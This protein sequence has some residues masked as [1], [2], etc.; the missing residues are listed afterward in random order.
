MTDVPVVICGAGPVGL[1]AS[2]ILSRFGIANMLIERRASPN[3]LPRARS[4]NCRTSE[5]WR[6]FGLEEDMKSISLPPEW[7]QYMVYQT[8]LAGEIVGK[9][10]GESMVQGA[11]SDITP[12]LFLLSSQDR[13]E[14]MLRETAASYATASVRYS[15]ELSTF[16]ADDE[17]VTIEVTNIATGVTETVR[18]QWLIAADGANSKIR[19][20]LGVPMEGEE[21]L[22]WYVNNHFHADLS[23]WTPGREGALLWI[24]GKGLE[25]VFQPLDGK[26][27]WMCQVNFDPAV[28]PASTFTREWVLNRIHAMIGDPAAANIEIELISSI[29]WSVAKMVATRLRVGRVLLAGDAAHRVPPFGGFGMNTGIQ[30]AHNLGWKLAY[31]LQKIAP[32][33]LLDSY[34]EERREVAQ[35]NCEF[36]WKNG[37]HVIAIG[38]AGSVQGGTAAVASAR[39]YGNWA[40]LDLGVY[41]ERGALVPDGTALPIVEDPIIDYVPCARPGSR[42]P[43]LWLR[44]N[45]EIISSLDLSEKDFVILAGP[46]GQAWVDAIAKLTSNEGVPL[47]AFRVGPSCT[48]Q[49]RDRSFT[50]LYGIGDDGAV[51][52][53]PDGHVAYRSPNAVPNTAEALDEVLDYVL[54][55]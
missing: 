18:C 34:D 45:S 20:H 30:T 8:S 47:R 44:H 53:R 25:G 4:M 22:R 26:R 37:Q 27:D 41:Y 38:S 42:A 31:V 48:L 14:P 39:S 12:A 35:R 49:P 19:Q 3:P 54:R 9:M 6:Q 50:K 24:V 7:T 55:R 10:Y 52:I 28:T 1:T 15:Q 16:Q 11:L 32:E 21:N 13:M 40:G 23:R 17:G 36:G 29:P 5:I 33:A 2:I 51:L 46:D 43:H